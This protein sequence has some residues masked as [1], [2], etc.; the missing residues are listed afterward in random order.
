MAGCTPSMGMD[1]WG[2]SP[3]SEDSTLTM[4][5]TPITTSRGQGRCCEVLSKGSL[6]AKRQADEQKSDTRLSRR[7]ELAQDSKDHEFA[8]YSKSGGC[9]VTVH[10]LIWGDLQRVR[11][12]VNRAQCSNALC[13]VAEV[14]SGRSSGECRDAFKAKDQRS[15]TRQHL[16]VLVPRAAGAKREVRNGV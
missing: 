5:L 9:V 4:L 7:V 16:V 10:V 2:A 12:A 3:L 6:S 1:L 11:F 13:V 8:R 14:S 15:R